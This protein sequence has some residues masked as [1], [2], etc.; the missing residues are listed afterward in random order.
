MKAGQGTDAKGSTKCW[1]LKR[2][3]MRVVM[4]AVVMMKVPKLHSKR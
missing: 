4:V 1:S 2:G 3:V